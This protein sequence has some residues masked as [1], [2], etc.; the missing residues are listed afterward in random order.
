ME[1]QRL[2]KIIGG[3]FGWLITLVMVAGSAFLLGSQQQ[4]PA[5]QP[6][7]GESVEE[8]SNPSSVISD[9]QQT[10][11]ADQTNNG[12]T[13][14][15]GPDTE[16]TN[17]LININSATV[18]Q[19]DKLPGIGPA[20]AQ[21][22]IDYRNQFGLFVRVDDLVNVKGIGPATLEKLRSQITL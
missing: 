18:S 16:P 8:M 1:F 2:E 14:T 21:A 12:T 4:A 7:T 19:L 20:K 6:Q 5:S 3:Q 22:I 10:L 13:T 9:L 15:E 17:G 11:A